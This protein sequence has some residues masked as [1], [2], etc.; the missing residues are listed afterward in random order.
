M[1]VVWT[2]QW[3]TLLTLDDRRIIDDPRISI[4]RPYTKDWNLHIR[5]TAYSDRGQYVCQ[6][7]TNPVK[8]KTVMLIV[9]GK[10]KLRYNC[11]VQFLNISSVIIDLPFY[12]I[13]CSWNKDEN[14]LTCLQQQILI[15]LVILLKI[16]EYY[17]RASYAP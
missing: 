16:S 7:N 11:S 1:Q 13:K 6:I 2:D 8:T 9:L 5:K 14:V 3:S 12:P 4:E 17:N 10:W 15:K